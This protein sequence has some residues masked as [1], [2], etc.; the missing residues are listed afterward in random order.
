MRMRRAHILFVSAVAL[1]AAGCARTDYVA[2]GADE[3]VPGAPTRHVGVDIAPSLIDEFPDCTI[4]LR[5]E[6]GP[7]LQKFGPLVEEAL[8]R[9]LA[10]KFTRVF[11]AAERG[12]IVRRNALDLLHESDRTEL[13]EIAK[14]DTLLRSR[15]VGPGK[16]YLVVW[17]QVQIGLEVS[18]IRA[19]D[20]KVLWRARHMADRSEGGIPFSP[21]GIVVDAYSSVTFSSDREIAESVIDDAVRRVV[22]SLSNLRNSRVSQ[23]PFRR[24]NPSSGAFDTSRTVKQRRL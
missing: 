20:G 9:H 23:A 18:M 13:A 24:L 4:I 10:R 2:L 19:R 6:T 17:S 3:T 16:T 14:C 15:V 12:V 1:L 22:R 5:P 21:I 7:G 8:G 11:D